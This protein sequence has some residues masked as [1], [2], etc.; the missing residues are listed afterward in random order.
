MLYSPADVLFSGK[1]YDIRENIKS[2]K[3]DSILH[4]YVFDVF[5]EFVLS[6][7]SP[8]SLPSAF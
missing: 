2:K 4:V 7:K 5:V 3:V 6:I 1:R 8:G